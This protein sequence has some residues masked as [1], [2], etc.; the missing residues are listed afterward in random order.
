M[1]LIL[2]ALMAVIL[3]GGEGLFMAGIIKVIEQAGATY[4][5]H[6]VGAGLFAFAVV[7]TTRLKKGY[8]VDSN[9]VYALPMMLLCSVIG[10]PTLMLCLGTDA[11]SQIQQLGTLLT[12]AAYTCTASCGFIGTIAPK[13][14]TFN[15]E[16]LKP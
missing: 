6:G 12:L 5:W 9:A 1:K 8:D 3:G 11:I 2:S 14:N 16:E 15:S 13:H 4:Y 7:Y 10:I